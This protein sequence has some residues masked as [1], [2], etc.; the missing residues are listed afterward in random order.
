M[1]SINLNKLSKKNKNKGQKLKLKK[2][3]LLQHLRENSKEN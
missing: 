2:R 3:L 1:L